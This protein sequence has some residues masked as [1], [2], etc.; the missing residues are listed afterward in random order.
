M[1]CAAITSKGTPCKKGIR[2][3]ETLYKGDFMYHLCG[4]TGHKAEDNPKVSNDRRTSIP[5]THASVTNDGGT[6]LVNLKTGEETTQL[7]LPNSKEETTVEN[8]EVIVRPVVEELSS[9]LK[10]LSQNFR[11][12]G[13]I[14]E[15][16]ARC[17]ERLANTPNIVGYAARL[18]NEI[19]FVTEDKAVKVHK[20][21]AS[22]PTSARTS[23]NN[24]RNRPEGKGTKVVKTEGYACGKCSHWEGNTYVQVR[25]ATIEDVQA[26]YQQD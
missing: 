11:F 2:T 23:P 12:V 16:K 17:R 25:H 8:I 1:F 5:P 4:G 24:R 13:T 20:T 18:G 22:L 14:E 9:T 15:F 21:L 19:L 7:T 26:C 3:G 6:T 10:C